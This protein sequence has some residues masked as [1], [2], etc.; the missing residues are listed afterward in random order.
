MENLKTLYFYLGVDFD[1]LGG[2]GRNSK[3]CELVDQFYKRNNLD[4]LI[5]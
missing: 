3:A 1:S 4:T 5:Q 2:E